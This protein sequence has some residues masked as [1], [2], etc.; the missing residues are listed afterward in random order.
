[1]LA[2]LA[3]AF[4]WVGFWRGAGQPFA[5][6]VA[7][8]AALTAGALAL[9][10]GEQ[11]RPSG[12]QD[13]AA[14]QKAFNIKTIRQLGSNKF[15]AVAAAL[16]TLESRVSREGVVTCEATAGSPRADFLVQRHHDARLRRI[17]CFLVCRLKSGR[18]RF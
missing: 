5:T 6:V 7:G 3:Q 1:M 17:L 15:F 16:A 2:V 13:A 8:L 11:Q 12:E 9:H 10:N 4:G 14:L 18:N